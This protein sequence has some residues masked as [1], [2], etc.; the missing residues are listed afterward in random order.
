MKVVSYPPAPLPGEGGEEGAL[1]VGAH[2]D[3]GGLTLLAQDS[4]GGLQVQKWDT[5]EWIDVTP[6]EGSLVVNIGQ[7]V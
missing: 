1:G 5:G 2:A 6:I 3:G 4:M 7:V